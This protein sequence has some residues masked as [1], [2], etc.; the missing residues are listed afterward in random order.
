M[1]NKIAK[2]IDFFVHEIASFNKS[3]LE[4]YCFLD[5]VSDNS[6]FVAE[7]GSLVTVIKLK[8]MRKTILSNESMFESSDIF[9]EK[10]KSFFKEKGYVMQFYFSK[11][12]DRSEAVLENNFKEYREVAKKMGFNMD[13][14]Y[15]EKIKKLKDYIIQE[16][17]F[18]VL[19]TRPSVAKNL[20]DEIEQKKESFKNMPLYKKSQDT[21]K[22]YNSIKQ[23][24]K[25]YVGSVAKA[26]KAI[27][28]KIE[29]LNIL[30]A[31]NKMKSSCDLNRVGENWQARTH[32]SGRKNN[33]P[34]LKDAEDKSI[35]ENDISYFL[36][37]KL[38]SQLIPS[39]IYHKD[40]ALVINNVYS[41]SLYIKIP[42]ETPTKFSDLLNSV[43][44]DIAFQFSFKIEGGG[45][46]N[47]GLKKL[48]AT[49]LTF[50]ATSNN[51]MIKDSIKYYS[52]LEKVNGFV[53]SKNIISVNVFGKDMDDVNEKT[54][55]MQS[56]LTNWGSCDVKEESNDLYEMF[57]N[58]L[59]AYD[60]RFPSNSSFI[61]PYEEAVFSLP[62][63]RPLNLEE[64]SLIVY[65]TEDKKKI[66]YN[67]M[68]SYLN[69]FNEMIVATPGSGKS[70]KSNTNNLS[71]VFQKKTKKALE[72]LIPLLFIIDVGPSS[73]GFIEFLKSIAPQKLKS[74]FKY[75]KV[76]NTKEESI[77]ILDTPLGCRALPEKLNGLVVSFLSILTTPI[78]GKQTDD[79][80]LNKLV[81]SA[82][83][84]FSDTGRS[85]RA[86]ESESD[87]EQIHPY[88]Y[89]K[90]KEH[91]IEINPKTKWWEL[92]DEFFKIGDLRTAK[93]CQI[94]AV[95]TLVDLIEV[96]KSNEDFKEV[97]EEQEINNIVRL[98]S[99][100][101]TLYPMF[102]D[103]TKLDL[104]DARVLSFDLND[105]APDG[106]GDKSAAKK[107]ALM[108]SFS[109][110]YGL[111][112]FF[113][114][115]NTYKK[116][117]SI[118][119]K[120]LG[121]LYFEYRNIPK[122]FVVDE[123]HRG[124]IIEKFNGEIVRIFR[125]SRKWN[126]S[127]CLL[128]QDIGDF[129]PEIRSLCSARFILSSK[130]A[131]YKN[132]KNIFNFD[133]DI[134]NVLRTKLTGA[135]ADGLPFVLNFDTKEGEFTQFLY[136]TLSGMELWA[137]T[138]TSEDV[139]MFKAVNSVFETKKAIEILAKEFPDGSVKSHIES[140]ITG[141][142][143]IDSILRD[144]KR[145]YIE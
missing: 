56:E 80:L 5:T 51:K 120:Y 10:T 96:V 37:P 93:L 107:S 140:D 41:R 42:Q 52:D 23:P 130:G 33:R 89:S 46:K 57:F 95:P 70:V 91:K 98:I 131:D 99:D 115:E 63:N 19:S 67:P 116:A 117:P 69:Y 16:D 4:D 7:D 18:M 143:N 26:L 74:A 121:D 114:E 78:E 55:I 27:D 113:Y 62:F 134:A 145:K 75:H 137:T 139:D 108:Y 31:S 30:K 48:L 106:K 12:K 71:F 22:I 97:Y 128:S 65:R 29:I 73:K 2:S 76:E 13:F 105:V 17:A 59:P 1:L 45:L 43:P 61:L 127:N 11:N 20:G 118:Y 3:N 81:M 72:A 119:K 34:V 47:T 54:N 88:I 110:I 133:N 14:F 135:S 68:S 94:Q 64:K 112:N 126:M 15:D 101:L 36:Y 44:D 35:K 49:I 103:R 38:K 124:G 8:G 66:N 138:S 77:N 32:L 24:H 85:V 83:K 25:T 92:V 28:I 90:I 6:T 87:L 21:F 102:S 132:Y 79:M 100:S 39:S 111:R 109:T 9:Y 84:N 82:Y 142:I 141:E 58:T 104:S 53:F 40:G 123:Y 60:V 122:R 136:S 86:I 50:D 144:I 125:E 129:S